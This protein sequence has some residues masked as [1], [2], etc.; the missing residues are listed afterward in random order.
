MVFLDTLNNHA[1]SKEKIPRANR[2]P[3]VTKTVGRA[4]MKRANFQK[5]DF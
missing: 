4:I 5:I 1:P 2:V 3:Y